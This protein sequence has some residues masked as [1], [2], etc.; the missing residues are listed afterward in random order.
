MK[1]EKV[2]KATTKKRISPQTEGGRNLV[3]RATKKEVKLGQRWPSTDRNGG[4]KYPAPAGQVSES[5][6]AGSM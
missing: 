4:N 1:T 2:L 5:H 3:V 6:W